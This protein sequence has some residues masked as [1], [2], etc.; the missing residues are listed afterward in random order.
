MSRYYYKAARARA[1]EL[2]LIN[3]RVQSN[4]AVITG[5]SVPGAL[6]VG[7]DAV[8]SLAIRQHSAILVFKQSKQSKLL[9]WLIGSK[10]ES[11]ILFREVDIPNA[12]LT[13]MT[14]LTRRTLNVRS[15]HGSSRLGAAR[16]LA[17]FPDD[18]DDV[19][20]AALSAAITTTDADRMLR[21][22]HQLL[23]SPVSQAIAA[24]SSLIIVPDR[25]LYALPFAALLD[26]N[27]KHLIEAK[28]LRVAP[29]VGTLIELEQRLAARPIVQGAARSL[30]V[31]DPDFHGTSWLGKSAGRRTC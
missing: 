29:S 11:S 9:I 22:C 20:E 16:G 23:I 19:D 25:D 27:G 1:F 14:E 4:T 26:E 17:E 3:Q 7:M 6:S 2:L 18:D 13:Q 30:I 31:G 10:G 8:R 15:R 28:A 21:R 12:L 5:T 24:E